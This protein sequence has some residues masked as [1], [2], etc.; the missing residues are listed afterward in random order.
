MR[1]GHA[2]CGKYAYGVA[3]KIFGAARAAVFHY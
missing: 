3:A 1:L 2:E